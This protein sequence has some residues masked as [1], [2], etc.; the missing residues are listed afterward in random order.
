MET[1]NTILTVILIAVVVYILF[2]PTNQTQAVVHALGGA[3]TTFTRVLSGQY[4][5]GSY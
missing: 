1:V 4:A 3:S 5:G 2:R